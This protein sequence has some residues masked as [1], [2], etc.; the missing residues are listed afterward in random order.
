M[1]NS[2]ENLEPTPRTNAPGKLA[3]LALILSRSATQPHLAV[4]GLLLIE[5]GLTFG[6][7]VGVTGQIRTASSVIA[8]L[9]SLLMG[10]LSVRFKHRTLLITGLV[11][12][13]L[14]ALGCS[15]SNSFAALLIAYSLKGFGGAMVNPMTGSLVGELLPLEARSKVIGWMLAGMSITYLITSPIAGFIAGLTGWRMAFLGFVMPFTLVSLILS[16]IGIPTISS[17]TG[18]QAVEGRYLDGFKAVFSRKSAIAC[19]LG[20]A[21]SEMTWSSALTFSISFFRQRFL[22]PIGWASILLSGM[23]FGCGVGSMFSGYLV[24]RLGRKTIATLSAMLLGVCSIMYVNIPILWLSV[25]VMFV[26]CVVSAIRYAAL[27]SLSLEMV[28][29][30]RGTMMSTKVFANGLGAALGTGL[31]GLMLLS[32]GYGGQGVFTGTMAIIATII[33]YL[34]VIDPTKFDK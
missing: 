8:I 9:F 4:T 13:S 18:S 34:L 24:N 7:P 3:L 23:A 1:G 32:Y 16:V 17:G 5:I 12:F 11:F 29:E 15:I 28:P 27:E 30:Y 10:V 31:G 26:N 33:I 21:L 14:S 20:S 25:V 19:L 22:V 2:F 6:T